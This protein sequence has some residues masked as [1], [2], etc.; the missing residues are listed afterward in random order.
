MSVA[1][2][3]IQQP[4]AYRRNIAFDRLVG[5]I[6]TQLENTVYGSAVPTSS[7]SN[8]DDER[9]KRLTDKLKTGCVLEQTRTRYWSNTPASEQLK[10]L[11]LDLLVRGSGLA[12]ERGSI[13]LEGSR[14]GVLSLHHGFYDLNR[15]GPV[16]FWEVYFGEVSGITAQILSTELD[17]GVV[18]SQNMLRSAVTP[19][20]NRSQIYTYTGQVVQHAIARLPVARNESIPTYIFGMFC[21]RQKQG[22]ARLTT[23]LLSRYPKSGARLLSKVHAWQSF[24]L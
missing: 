12:I 17:G 15:G 20:L 18:I 19:H 3:R 9:T 24:S 2:R 6:C 23:R 22:N 1:S 7:A 16:G 21:G 4:R 5:R 10:S 11:K 8:W 14:I 13:L